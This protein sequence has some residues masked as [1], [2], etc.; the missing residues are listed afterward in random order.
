[1]LIVTAFLGVTLYGL[2][3]E[4]ETAQFEPLGFRPALS[5]VAYPTLIK[6]YNTIQYNT[7]EGHNMTYNNDMSSD[8]N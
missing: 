4:E 5:W 7:I 3:A 2:G 1:M 6:V 8:V